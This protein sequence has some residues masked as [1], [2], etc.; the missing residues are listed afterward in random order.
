V[1]VSVVN[2]PAVAAELASGFFLY[3]R[4][5]H[6]ERL[7]H[8]LS[9]GEIGQGRAEREE[10]WDVR[11]GDPA[12][13]VI[14]GR[15]GAVTCD[16]VRDDDGVWRGRWL[17]HERM[18]VEL[19][20]MPDGPAYHDWRIE[21]GA[22]E[23]PHPDY[24]VH[25][26]VLPL[27]HIECVCQMD[28]VPYPAGAFSHLRAND[29]LEHQS[30]ALVPSTLREW[31]R[32]LAPDGRAYIQVPDGRYVIDQWRSGAI[33][34][35]ALNYWLLGGHGTDRAAHTGVDERGVPRWIWNAHH[36]VFTAEWLQ[37][38]LEAAGFTDVR[39]ESDGGSNLMCWSKR[40]A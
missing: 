3:R 35:R 22:G 26:D 37:E 1:E 21:I 13:L 12:V 9:G 14:I 32:L 8:L 17:S 27:P 33:D 11:L 4:V 6:D 28:V 19:R 31:A 23:H 10:R 39:I 5:G 34:T 7:L 24:H 30:W 20:P 18:A 38:L 36:T 2:A 29:V 15:D 16:L 25:T 40:H